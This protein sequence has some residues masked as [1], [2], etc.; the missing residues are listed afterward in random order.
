MC[1]KC[2]EKYY[3][4]NDSLTVEVTIYFYFEVALHNYLQGYNWEF[5]INRH[6]YW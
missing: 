1:T 4:F 2:L 6:F 5:N 3:F